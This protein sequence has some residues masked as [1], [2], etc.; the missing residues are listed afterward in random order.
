M[1]LGFDAVPALIQ[2]LDDDG[3]TRSVVTSHRYGG[4]IWVEP[5]H[6][7]AILALNEIAGINLYW[8]VK[9]YGMLKAEE[10]EAGLRKQI[11]DWW[12]GVSKTGEK[13]YL[14]GKLHADGSPENIA[15]HLLARF[16]ED[17]IHAIAE[18]IPAL[19]DPSHRAKILLKFLWRHDTPECRA[20]S[21]AQEMQTGPTLENRVAAALESARL[22][23]ESG[24][25]DAMRAE[26]A[27]IQ[28]RMSKSPAFPSPFSSD[29][30]IGGSPRRFSRFQ[31]RA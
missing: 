19:T 29:P 18:A 24:A 28:P 8:Q 12:A 20:S 23:G 11:A 5:I 27:K 9:D 25:L 13:A 2:A 4:G 30:E 7:I 14:I 15:E 16:P 17:G 31:R 3:I 6:D 21:L 1:S 22:L 10:R 26:W